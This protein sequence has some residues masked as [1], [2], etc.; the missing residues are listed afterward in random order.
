MPG[1]PAPSPAPADGLAWSYRIPILNNRYVWVRWGWAALAFGLGFA[2]A[3]GT[4]LVVFFAG[5][6]GGVG[7]ALKVYAAIALTAGLGV[8]GLGL[9]AALAVANGV[10]TRFTL[11]SQGAAATTSESAS[12]SV[13]NA[14][15]FWGGSSPQVRNLVAAAS[16]LLPSSGEAKWEDVRRAQFDERRHVITLRRRWHHPLRLYVPPERF[17]E[18]AA[19]ARDHVAPTARRG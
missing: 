12:E 5:A 8:V 16:L 4:P 15:L 11:S 10:T 7:F 17:S 3:L 18:A 13:E 1:E 9:F 6:N 14:A 19:F 2:I